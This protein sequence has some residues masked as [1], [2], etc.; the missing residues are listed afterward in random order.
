MALV[1]TTAIKAT[2]DFQDIDAYDTGYCCA[3]LL[4]H[5]VAITITVCGFWASRRFHSNYTGSTGYEILTLFSSFGSF[6]YA[7]FVFQS[8]IMQLSNTKYNGPEKIS[9]LTNY[10]P[11]NAM[12]LI[13]VGVNIYQV[14]IQTLFMLNSSKI[15]PPPGEMDDI[16]VNT[17]RFKKAMAALA[18]CNIFIWGTESFIEV[19]NVAKLYQFQRA[20][21]GETSWEM[22]AHI[23]YPI[24]TFY[25]FNSSIFLVNI[26]QSM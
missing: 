19:Q 16:Q 8:L 18:A 24:K 3:K 14:C 25:R 4:Y 26:H 17:D 12:A 6:V 11:A 21:Y 23:T 22:I 15:K 9:D 20:F 7:S 10:S 2:E 1:V 13:E 5:I